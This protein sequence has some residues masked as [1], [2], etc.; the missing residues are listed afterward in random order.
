MALEERTRLYELLVRLDRSET[1]DRIAGMQVQTITEVLRDG[2][3]VAASLGQA[4]PVDFAA[5]VALM[6]PDDRAALLA[7]LVPPSP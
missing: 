7:A 3:L 6:H 2:Q 5:L 1:G 4:Q